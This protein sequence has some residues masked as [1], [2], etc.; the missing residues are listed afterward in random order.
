MAGRAC[1]R[2]NASACEW[3]R[4]C[5]HP[6]RGGRSRCNTKQRR[7]L[8]PCPA[9]SGPHR[10]EPSGQAQSKAEGEPRVAS[11]SECERSDLLYTRRRLLFR[12]GVACGSRSCP[13][14]AG[15]AHRA[16]RPDSTD[17][18][19]TQLPL[20]NSNIFPTPARDPETQRCGTPT[21]NT[22]RGAGGRAPAAAAAAPPPLAPAERP[23]ALQQRW[24]SKARRPWA[25]SKNSGGRC[26][27]E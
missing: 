3:G 10:L 11:G 7:R 15:L 5:F 17:S 19:P 22:S 21:L 12:G 2:R 23:P 18:S 26:T 20:R 6:G 16:R 4:L 25:R 27:S 14:A 8:L 1:A 24:A 9:F 13:A